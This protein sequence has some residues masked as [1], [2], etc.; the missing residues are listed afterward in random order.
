MTQNTK[1]TLMYGGAILL[2]SVIAYAI[3][4]SKKSK[5]DLVDNARVTEDE[6]PTPEGT[7]STKPNPFTQYVNNPLPA[8]IGWKSSG[9]LYS[10]L[11]NFL[12]TNTGIK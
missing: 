4:S 2:V 5:L 11:D 7:K 3:Y 1:K 6:T 10:G 8:S 12:N 9:N